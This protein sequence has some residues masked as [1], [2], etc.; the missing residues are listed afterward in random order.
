MNSDI[1]HSDTQ[2]PTLRHPST[3]TFLPLIIKYFETEYKLKNILPWDNIFL[4]NSMDNLSKIT[5][6]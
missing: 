6:I 1:S 3:H 2:C 5:F 4:I